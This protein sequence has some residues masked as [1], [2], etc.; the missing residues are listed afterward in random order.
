MEKLKKLLNNISI[1]MDGDIT[2]IT[3]R[4]HIRIDATDARDR[5]TTMILDLNKG[6]IEIAQAMKKAMDE[7]RK[8]AHAL[9]GW[10]DLEGATNQFNETIKSF[11]LVKANGNGSE[12]SELFVELANHVISK[13]NE[14]KWIKIF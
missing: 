3:T 2:N 11:E 4:L 14:K 7:L 6:D 8:F 1:H 10:S 9:S 13:L 5:I 12:L